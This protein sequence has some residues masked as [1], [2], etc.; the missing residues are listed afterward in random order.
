MPGDVPQTDS[1]PWNIATVLV[2]N[3][4]S[5][6]RIEWR[7]AE[8]EMRLFHF[9]NAEYG[10]DDIRRRRLKISLI[11]DLN[12]PFELLSIELS[13]KD[14]R[15]ALR[16]TKERISKYGGILCFS[17]RWSNPV[18]WSH[19]ADK[20]RGLCLGFE[21]PDA[22]L[23]PVSYT[24]KRLISEADQLLT[25]DYAVNG[26]NEATILKLLSTKYSHWK[27]ENEVR[28]FVGLLD[29]DPESGLYFIGFSDDL[30]LVQVSVGA[31]SDL[32]R[33]EVAAALGLLRNTVRVFKA[34]LA[35]KS[36]KVVRN[37]DES[38]WV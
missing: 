24:A 19:Y 10:I 30:R 33:E 7:Y 8:F 4:E 16:A 29:K 32:S 31:R 14:L 35:F 22:L 27:Y 5:A 17:K 18:Q 34:R 9:L 38:L 36:F 23:Q 20:H 13:N 11:P 2:S 25:T 12:D 26:D 21:V 6:E 3:D 37:R 28:C 1:W 15:Q